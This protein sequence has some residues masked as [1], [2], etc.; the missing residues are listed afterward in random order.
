MGGFLFLWAGQHTLLSLNFSPLRSSRFGVSVELMIKVL[1]PESGPEAEF[2]PGKF[3]LEM[4]DKEM[5]DRVIVP[6]HT[7]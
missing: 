5:T 6:K 7:T 1:C 4:S 2:S 3:Y